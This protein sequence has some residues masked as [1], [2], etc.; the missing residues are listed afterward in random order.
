MRLTSSLFTKILSWFLLNLILVM[1]ALVIFFT[2]QSHVN[3]HAIF[4]QLITD[5]LRT[6]GML[7]SHDL[8]L[9]PQTKWPDVLARHAEIH[10]IDFAVILPD[11]SNF[12][13]KGGD[14]PET[15]IKRARETLRRRPPPGELPP[16]EFFDRKRRHRPHKQKPHLMM[17]TQNPNRYWTGI[18][19]PMSLEKSRPPQ[20]WSA[21]GCV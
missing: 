19:V 3:L 5:R 18:K 14:L 8:N 4:G 1:T 7:I 16:D 10:Q 2:F 20:T 12:F 13:S 15:V 6:A 17:R 21:L 9:V 11:E